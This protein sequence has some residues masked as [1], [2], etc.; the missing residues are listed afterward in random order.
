MFH[1]KSLVT[2]YAGFTHFFDEVGRKDLFSLRNEIYSYL[3]G[4]SNFYRY[5]NAENG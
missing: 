2:C 3:R 5:S 1:A 4:R